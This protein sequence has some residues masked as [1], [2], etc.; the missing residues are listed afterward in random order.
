MEIRIEPN[1]CITVFLP[2]LV[3][4]NTI[5]VTVF[6]PFVLPCK[7]L[8]EFLWDLHTVVDLCVSV[9]QAEKQSSSSL[10]CA[11]GDFMFSRTYFSPCFV[12]WQLF[13][14]HLASDPWN[15]PALCHWI[16]V[17]KIWLLGVKVFS[18][19]GSCVCEDM[20]KRGELLYSLGFVPIL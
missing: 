4:I 17:Q 2:Y 14:F 10:V 3:F 7:W 13:A 1:F 12:S 9:I 16:S 8:L 6:A 15:K 20:G 11:I 19:R 18:D 5:K